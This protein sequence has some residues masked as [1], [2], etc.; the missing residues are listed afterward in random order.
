MF[1]FK[2]DKQVLQ[3][4]KQEE[5]KIDIQILSESEIPVFEN[6]EET[7]RQGAQVFLENERARDLEEAIILFAT[8]IRGLKYK[9]TEQTEEGNKKVILEE[10]AYQKVLH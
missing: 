8:M 6:E 5:P 4:V 1:R 7:I 3:V 2:K 9:R 10:T